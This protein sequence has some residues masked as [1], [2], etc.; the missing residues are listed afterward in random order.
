MSN[1]NGICIYSSI[2]GRM[3]VKDDVRMGEK[4]NKKLK[5]AA[6]NRK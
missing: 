4:L 5:M 1:F 3:I 2:V 6:W